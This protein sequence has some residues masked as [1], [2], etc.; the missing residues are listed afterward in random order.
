MPRILARAARKFC[1]WESP[2]ISSSYILTNC[3]LLAVNVGVDSQEPLESFA[4]GCRALLSLSLKEN[5]VLHPQKPLR[6][7]LLCENAKCAVLIAR[8][9]RKA[10]GCAD[11]DVH[12]EPKWLPLNRSITPNLHSNEDLRAETRQCAKINEGFTS[13]FHAGASGREALSAL[14]RLLCTRLYLHCSL[15]SSFSCLCVLTHYVCCA[16]WMR[17]MVTAS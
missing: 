5:G 10:K 8:D 12:R 11:I 17:N 15:V 6:L 3:V 4:R 1:L 9:L 7:P 16:C 14:Q 2:A 13:P